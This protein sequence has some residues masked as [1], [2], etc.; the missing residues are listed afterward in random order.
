MHDIKRHTA[1][2]I[3]RIVKYGIDNGYN[4]APLDSSVTCHQR[5]AN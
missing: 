4:F 1:L 2:A 3:G 5:I